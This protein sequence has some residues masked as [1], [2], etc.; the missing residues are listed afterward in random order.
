MRVLKGFVIL[1]G[2]LLLAG[3]AILL[4]RVIERGWNSPRSPS[5]LTE[6]SPPSPLALPPGG[7]ITALT[8]WG[9]GIA[10]LVESGQGEQE[11]WGIDAQGTLKR[12]LRFQRETE[13]GVKT[14]KP[15]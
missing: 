15:R 4:Y 12:Q 7:R 8:S 14:P 13:P 11:I 2:V 9:N 6:S 3:F 5:P 10:L 1:G